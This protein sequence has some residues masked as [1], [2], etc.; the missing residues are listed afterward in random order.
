L[1]TGIDFEGKT[2]TCREPATVIDK[3]AHFTLE[4]DHLVISVGAS[5]NTFN[6]PGVEDNAFFLKVRNRERR[7]NNPE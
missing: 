5:N 1:D 6:I 7:D 4:Y 3:G 2:I